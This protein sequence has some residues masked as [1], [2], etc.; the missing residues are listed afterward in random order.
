VIES[1]IPSFI[2]VVSTSV[3]F[4]VGRL[5]GWATRHRGRFVRAGV[6]L[7]S[8][9]F[10]AMVLTGSGSRYALLLPAALTAGCFSYGRRRFAPGIFDGPQP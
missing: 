2:V 10:A 3:A 4:A 6:V 9:W 7:I 5:I 8:L 1:F